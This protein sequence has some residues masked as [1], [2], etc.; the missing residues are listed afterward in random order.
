MY[1]TFNC[2]VGLIL[3]VDE[4]DVDAAL[5]VLNDAGEKAWLLSE[6]ADLD[7]ENQ[8]EIN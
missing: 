7:G 6:I 3:V 2:G 5:A 1:R 8:V 4:Q